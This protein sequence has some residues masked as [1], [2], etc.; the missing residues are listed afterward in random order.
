MASVDLDMDEL[1]STFVNEA[2]E[3]IAALEAGLLALETKPDDAEVK[4]E[5]LRRA[6]TIKGNASCVGLT[7]VTTFA[8]AYEELLERV[9][10]DPAVI[11]L[12]LSGID[13]LR[14]MVSG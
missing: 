2:A 11:T 1:M 13:T 7:S 3:D 10:P 5:L 6:H 4:Q 8:H 12:L 14:Q 9:D